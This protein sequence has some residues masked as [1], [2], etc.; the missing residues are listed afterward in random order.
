MVYYANKRIF[1]H[2]MENF[3][4]FSAWRGCIFFTVLCHSGMKKINIQ[5]GII[6]IVYY[7][8]YFIHYLLYTHGGATVVTVAVIY[9]GQQLASIN[10]VTVVS[11]VVKKPAWKAVL[12]EAVVTRDKVP[13]RYRLISCLEDSTS[14]HIRATSISVKVLPS[15]QLFCIDIPRTSSPVTTASLSTATIRT[16]SIISGAHQFHSPGWSSTCQL[17]VSVFVIPF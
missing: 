4:P 15:R 1:S 17:I 7:S 3:T 9:H 10:V 5:A 8:L 16:L 13:G 14:L 11:V 2:N 6:H 12:S